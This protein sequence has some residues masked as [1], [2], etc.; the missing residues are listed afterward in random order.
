MLVLGCFY[1]SHVCVCVCVIMCV[2]FWIIFICG[3]HPDIATHFFCLS[4]SKPLAKGDV[5]YV[6]GDKAILE[7]KQD[8]SDDKTLAVI[9]W[10]EGSRKGRF[11]VTDMDCLR[12]E[13]EGTGT[14]CD[15]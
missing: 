11:H 6:D 10:V 5:V 1:V 8:L 9:R 13:S 14:E 15:F 3:S 7:Q 4:D 12:K 2:C